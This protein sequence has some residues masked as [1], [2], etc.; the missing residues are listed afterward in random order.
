MVECGPSYHP[1]LL[2]Q[3]L[4]TALKISPPTHIDLPQATC[5]SQILSQSTCHLQF[6]IW[7]KKVCQSKCHIQ[8]LNYHYEVDLITLGTYFNSCI[9]YPLSS[10]TSVLYSIFCYSE[11]DSE[12]NS[13]LR[14]ILFSPKIAVTLE[15]ILLLL[16]LY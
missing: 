16:Q 14:A 12:E 9:M 11:M 4:R 10:D 15:Q 3:D 2:L 1:E 5:N 8:S 13:A 7:D 6:K